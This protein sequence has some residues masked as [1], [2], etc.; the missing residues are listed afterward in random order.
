MPV[1]M[2]LKV[3]LQYTHHVPF[4]ILPTPAPIVVLDDLEAAVHKTFVYRPKTF[5]LG[6]T[7]VLVR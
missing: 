3:P 7:L 1:L 4:P 5:D 6:C 2:I